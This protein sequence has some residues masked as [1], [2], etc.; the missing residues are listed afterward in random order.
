MK[1]LIYAQLFVQF[2]RMSHTPMSPEEIQ[3]EQKELAFRQ[4][5]FEEEMKLTKE[6]LEKSLDLTY[7]KLAVVIIVLIIIIF[8]I[9]CRIR[10]GTE[11]KQPTTAPKTES[12]EPHPQFSLLANSIYRSDAAFDNVN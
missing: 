4:H 11:M 5:K 12:L 9:S 3:L 6:Y 10:W 1:D 7:L 2:F 8:Y